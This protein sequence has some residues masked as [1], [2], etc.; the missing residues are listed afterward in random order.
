M[1]IIKSELRKVKCGIGTI[2]YTL[3]RKPVK[4]INLRI[5]PDGK[6]FVSA[7]KHVTVKYIDE[8]VSSKQS[9]ISRALEK[10]RE[11]NASKEK[12]RLYVSGEIFYIL[13]KELKLDVLASDEEGVTLAESIIIMRVSDPDNFS[14]KEK[15]MN[16]WLKEFQGKIFT[17]I[18]QK[19][20]EI[21]QRYNLKYPTIKIRKMKTRWGSCNPHK[22]SITL[23]SKLIEVPKRCIEYV[24]VHE[25]AHFIHPNHSNKFYDFMT[26][27]MPDWKE[28]RN[29]LKLYS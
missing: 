24:V 20:H 17:E 12:P 14:E 25:F 18:C 22:G 2:E 11:I 3:T 5:K 23:N 15:L 29:Q 27:L 21:F 1:I 9:F 8:F 28:C 7:N 4:N 6:I 16:K 10:Y 19:T 13:G 26:E